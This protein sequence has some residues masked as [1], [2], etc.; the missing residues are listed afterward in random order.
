MSKSG[1]SIYD[2][3][4]LE[5]V[6]TADRPSEDDLIARYFAPLAGPGGLGLRDDAALIAPPAGCE[7]VLTVDGL[8][9]GVHF[10]ADDPPATIARK[11][12]R[13]NLSDLAAKGAAPLG[14]LLTLALPRDWKPKWLEV[15][16]QNLGEDAEAFACPLLGGDT[17]STPG[18]LTLSITALGA[19]PRGRMVPRDG[20]LA[21]DA[22]YVS[23][24]IGDAALGLR[25]RSEPE[26][27]RSMGAEAR[28]FLIDRYLVPQPRLALAEALRQNASGAMDVSD[29]LVGDLTKM[30]RV[31]GA[32]AE[33]EVARI[34]LSDA[35]RAAIGAEPR[36]LEAALTG[37]D[38]YEILAS[39]PQD[40]A[41]AFEAAARAA[42]VAVARIGAV[43]AGQGAPVFR[44]AR[45]AAMSF[46]RGSYSHF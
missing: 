1:R 41:Q 23:G 46:A 22:L 33:V 35:A 42:N 30:L 25:L 6:V 39:V 26:R 2:P 4:E 38:D 16:A 14:F 9:A 5:F 43:A 40:R 10:F 7:I 11:A 24:T 21:G 3:Q 31:S 37:G 18:P 36:L 29:G 15:F 44:D 28:S 12:L 13:V 20:A 34:P 27:T 19:T 8:V 32:T 17:V 45:G